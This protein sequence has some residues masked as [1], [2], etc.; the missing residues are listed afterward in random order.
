[1][2]EKDH[3]VRALL[4]QAEEAENNDD[5]NLAIKLY[6]DI[7]KQDPL[8]I[9]SYN[10]Q[11]KLFRRNKEHKKELSTI[12]AALKAYEKFY[13]KHSKKKSQKVIDISQKL[14][15]SIG[16]VDKKGTS[17]YVPEPLAGWIKRKTVVEKKLK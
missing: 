15:K 16:L 5:T 8:H 3:S 10:S 17:V 11:M 1:M 7:L 14:N 4:L 6:S 12:N 13:Q 2:E 9:Q